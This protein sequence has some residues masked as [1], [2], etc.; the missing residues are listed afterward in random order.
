M[1]LVWT[2]ICKYWIYLLYDVIKGLA[3][4]LFHLFR[5]LLSHSLQADAERC[6]F[7]CA[8]V[9]AGENFWMNFQQICKWRT[10]I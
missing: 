8:I 10:N 6:L 3:D 2:N 5:V 4:D 1:I 7:G 9:S